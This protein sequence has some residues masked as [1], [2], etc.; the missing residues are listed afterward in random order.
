MNQPYHHG[1]LRQALLDAAEA[2][3]DRNGVDAL[4]LRGAARE[5]GV[6]HGAPAHHFGDLAGLLSDVAAAGFVRLRETI[7]AEAAGAEPE[8]YVRALGRGYVRFARRHPGVFLLMFRS[9]RLDWSSP[10]LSAAGPAAFALLSR[11]GPDAQDEGDAVERLAVAS[12]RW[13]LVHGLAMLVIDGRLGA[14]ADMVEEADLER[15]VEEVL[16]RGLP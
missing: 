3:I 15:L 6:S 11:R 12:T 1:S 8:D 2:I 5:A 14:M 10:A 4:T 9:G 16:A 13:S 7:E